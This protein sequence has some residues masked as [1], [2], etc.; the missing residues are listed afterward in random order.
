MTGVLQTVVRLPKDMAA[1]ATL[2]IRFFTLWFA[3]ITGTLTVL[4][5]RNML[6]TSSPDAADVQG[7]EAPGPIDPELAYEQ[8]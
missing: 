2:M 8:V 6:F 7:V 5:W 3:V 1:T 4:I